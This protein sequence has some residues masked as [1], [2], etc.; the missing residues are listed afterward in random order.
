MT[1][2]ANAVGGSLKEDAMMIGTAH[3][4]AADCNLS[5][6]SAIMQHAFRAV[7]S[8]PRFKG[9]GLHGAHAQTA[10]FRQRVHSRAATN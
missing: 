1:V 9:N 2:T 6:R 5:H 7:F 8:E 3:G 10:L 4:T